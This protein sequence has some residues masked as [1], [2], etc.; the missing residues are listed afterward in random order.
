MLL[1]ELLDDP[2]LGLEVLVPG[3]TDRPVRWVHS[4]E[5]ADPG[6]FLRGGEV[7]LTTGAWQR[8][9]QTP[10]AW[11]AEVAGA[12][13][14]AIGFGRLLPADEPPAELVAAA[15]ERGLTC[16][17]VPVA[18]PFVQ[19]AEA[20]VAAKRV[21]WEA[22]LRSQLEHHGAIVAALCAE[23][24]V[25][26]VLRVLRR[27]LRI[28]VAVVAGTTTHGPVP[29]AGCPVALIG[30]GLADASLVLPRPL[31]ELDV[32]VQAAVSSAMPFLALELE[33]ERAVRAT[34]QRY[35]WE[36][37]E[38]IATGAP[39]ASVTARLELLGVPVERR[40]RCLVV[41]GAAPDAVASVLAPYLLVERADDVVCLVGEDVSR[42]AVA[43]YVGVGQAAAAGEL[44]VSLLQARH[45]ADALAARGVEGWLTH[46]QLA[47]PAVLLA[48]QDPAVLRAL[49]HTVLGGVLDSDRDRGTELVVS[50]R[51]FLDGGGR[52]QETADALHVHINTLRH[53][54][55]RVEELTGR[56]LASTADRV[57]LFLALRAL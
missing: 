56:S 34:E 53:R 9:G 13:A 7:V 51:A 16:F 18:V 5:V 37:V 46:E 12:G 22:P 10:A 29:E 36:V 32:D 33:R 39:A 1:H 41:R 57:D 4:I 42:V 54:M 21:E 55:K 25:D 23:R 8:L 19:L 15:T 6:E 3:R 52:W 17:V 31:A 24:G 28:E 44:R 11:V 2:A 27:R 47:S 14:I 30:E 38:W 48:A 49:A 43:G 40:L 45:A 20:F 26:S 35:A 50:L